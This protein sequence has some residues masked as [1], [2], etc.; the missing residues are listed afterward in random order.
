[1]RRLAG[2]IAHERV[3]KAHGPVAVLD[4]PVAHQKRQIARKPR[5]VGH[6]K[7]QIARAEIAPHDRG[8]HPN[9]GPVARRADQRLKARLDGARQ[10][11]GL[12]RPAPPLDQPDKRQREQGD[13]PRPP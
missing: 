5:A 9:L 8:L 2:S 11:L 1:M 4:Q 12:G 10:A 3:A 6:Q 7:P 13:C